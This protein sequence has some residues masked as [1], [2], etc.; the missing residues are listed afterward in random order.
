LNEEQV[1]PCYA[2]IP[3]FNLYLTSTNA[4]IRVNTKAYKTP[5]KVVAINYYFA[6]IAFGSKKKISEQ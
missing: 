2:I 1:D 3:L 4:V 5:L 6:S